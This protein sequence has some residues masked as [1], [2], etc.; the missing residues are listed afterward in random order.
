[1]AISYIVG[2]I[3]NVYCVL[4]CIWQ[5]RFFFF[6]RTAFNDFHCFLLFSTIHL[7]AFTFSLD[8][9][10]SKNTFLWLPFL[11]L[12]CSFH[13]TSLLILCFDCNPFQRPFQVDKINA[14]R[15]M[16]TCQSHHNKPMIRIHPVIVS[17]WKLANI[18][19]NLY[20]AFDSRIS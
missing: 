10:L 11:S 4:L 15:P 2:I 19:L 13:F 14:I 7:K 8:F 12:F 1:M 3:G 20:L 17:T 18:E 9:M 5:R 16:R 6:T